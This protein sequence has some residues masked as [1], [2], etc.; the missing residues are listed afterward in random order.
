PH[1]RTRAAGT[2]AARRARPR[3]R[4]RRAT[5]AVARRGSAASSWAPSRDGAT[6]AQSSLQVR[7]GRATTRARFEGSALPH[8]LD[9]LLRLHLLGEERRLDAVEETLEPADEL[10]LRDPQLR[11]ARCVARERK[12]HVAELLA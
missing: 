5:P 3:A 12:R 4:P 9:L 1:P 7:A 8:L 11:V 10:R 2:R 6:T